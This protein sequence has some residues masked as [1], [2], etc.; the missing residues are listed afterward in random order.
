MASTEFTHEQLSQDPPPPESDTNLLSISFKGKT[1]WIPI[2][3]H[4]MHIVTC[5]GVQ[6]GFGLVN[7]YTNHLQIV[8]TSNYNSLTGLHPLKITLTAAHIKFSMSSLVV[9]W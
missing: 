4:C 9:S 6:T 1:C 2:C 5:V 7:E 3:V 8:T